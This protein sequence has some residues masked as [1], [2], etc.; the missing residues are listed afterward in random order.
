[1]PFR[2]LREFIAK[3]KEVDRCKVIEGADWDLEIG[4]LTELTVSWPDSPM[5]L[6]DKIPGY[7]AG[8][9]V[10]TNVVSSLNRAALAL[11]MPLDAHPLDLLR[12]WRERMKK[13]KPIPPKEVKWG[14]ILENV[15]TG[16]EID[17]T[18]F[19]APKWH[20]MDG[21]RYVG[22]ADLFIQRDSSVSS[23]VNIGTY[24]VQVHDRDTLGIYISRGHHGWM[25]AEGYWRQGK[26][27]PVVITFGQEPA[28][29]I[30]VTHSI[31]HGVSEY[32]YTGSI[33]GEPVEVI[34][35]EWTKLPIPATAEIAVE[36]EILPPEQ[37]QLEGPFGEW[38]GYYASGAR[39][40]PVV[41]VKA[42]MF[43]N[44][45]II[46]GAPPLKPQAVPGPQI[47]IDFRAASIWEYIDAAGVPEV[48]GVYRF[49]GQIFV[50]SIRQRYPGHSRN[51][52]TAALGC[53]AAA[54]EARFIIMVDDDIDPSDVNDV[55]WAVATRCDP[56]TSTDILTA[57]WTDHLDPRIEPEDRAKGNLT[58]SKMIIDACRPFH[59]KERFPPVNAM[60][61]ELKTGLLKK[62][63]HL[64]NRDA[65]AS[66]R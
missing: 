66:G 44:D 24:R 53:Y 63:G 45:P 31:P 10:L 47:G 38:L 58:T 11:D 50:I 51:A 64:L 20:E 17:C 5:L 4:G 56:K 21:G 65:K 7:S 36:G 34:T 19:P 26:S 12:L 29:F 8:Y 41:K 13:A 48:R 22:T 60:S 2:D 30:A 15:H 59:W 37:G 55:L 6:F 32:D 3:V 43:R 42:L 28:I 57:C 61:P 1:M 62:W 14:P 54:K 52:A 16:A 49:G 9:R 35:G 40:E 46:T 25:I 18:R 33:R 23:W 39:V 27:C